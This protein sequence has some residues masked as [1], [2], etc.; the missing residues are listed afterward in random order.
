[1]K[2]LWFVLY[3]IISIAAH[4]QLKSS[5][6]F[7]QANGF[8]F[9]MGIEAAD[10]AVFLIALHSTVHIFWPNR[11]GGDSGL[12]P[13]RRGA[14]A[15]FALWPILMASLAFVTGNFA[16]VNTGQYCYL[17]MEPWWSRTALSWIPRYINLLLILLMYG[18]SYMYIRVMLRRYSRRNSEI[19]VGRPAGVVPPTPPLMS[20]D[21]I[22]LSPTGSMRSSSRTPSM[23]KTLE[24]RSPSRPREHLM[25]RK[26]FKGKLDMLYPGMRVRRHWGWAGFES[27]P[28]AS[29]TPDPSSAGVSPCGGAAFPGT[30]AIKPLVETA[31]VAEA[32]IPLQQPKLA[33]L[34]RQ[35]LAD[36]LSSTKSSTA[37]ERISPRL[38]HRLLAK[39]VDDYF[40]SMVYSGR[41]RAHTGSQV[42]I[43]RVLGEG[44]V[45]VSGIDL[46]KPSPILA[47]DQAAFESGGI[48]RSRERLRRQLRYL[49][50]YP[51]V[52]LCI[53]IF[54][55]ANDLSVFDGSIQKRPPYWLAL[56]SLIS[57]S[58]QGLAD[59]FVFYAREKPWRHLRGGFWESLGL[60]CVRNLKFSLRKDSGRTREEMFNDSQRARSRR[61][62]ELELENELRGSPEVRRPPTAG[63]KN[64]WD[65]DFEGP[66]SRRATMGEEV[67]PS[68]NRRR[69]SAE[70][71]PRD[72]KR[73]SL[74][75]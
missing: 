68:G 60:D 10:A 1:M 48:S 59:S 32:S 53:W 41:G 21:L 46:E 38:H 57:L 73:V 20:H 28:S 24:E 52:Y 55:F 50:V 23:M 16:Y 17:P 35:L 39:H 36:T 3:D 63:D 30:T 72:V 8:F 74:S 58:I 75:A 25:M 33:L 7:C 45:G 11:A 69:S 12:Y 26:S 9:A 40:T 67:G 62:E 51:A 71:L 6:A 44:P 70:G 29:H 14:Y 64:W 13:Y 34:K 37:G 15:F 54:P 27:A 5:S 2:S 22:P 18:S 47:L 56:C 43:Q 66:D 42:E 31:Q 4:R 19:P 61:E 65:A 49:F